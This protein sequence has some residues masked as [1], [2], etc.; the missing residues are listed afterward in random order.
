MKKLNMFQKFDF[1]AWQ[2]GKKF[3]VATVRYNEKR[4]CVTL[5][6][7]ITEDKTDYGDKGISNIFEK[8]N[9]HCIQDI[10]E[11]DVDKYSV[12]DSIIFKNIGKCSVYGEYNSQLSVEAIVEVAKK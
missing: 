3:M 10:L 8:F 12:G 2:S 5:S 1:V 6:V 11:S 9:V 4:G 7:A